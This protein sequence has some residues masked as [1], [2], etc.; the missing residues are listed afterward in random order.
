MSSAFVGGD[1]VL[2]ESQ[3]PLTSLL[4]A[5]AAA[6]FLFGRSSRW[7]S[8][9]G[10]RLRLFGRQHFNLEQPWPALAGD[11]QSLRLRVVGDAVE[12]VY[13]RMAED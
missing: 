12:H 10:I 6:E 11:E 13:A 3:R 1:A 4:P 8:T 5:K 7:S 2:A 9:K